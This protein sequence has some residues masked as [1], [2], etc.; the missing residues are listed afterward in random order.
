MCPKIVNLNKKK[1]NDI[2]VIVNLTI[3][4]VKLTNKNLTT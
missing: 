4:A 2:L 3:A 1:I